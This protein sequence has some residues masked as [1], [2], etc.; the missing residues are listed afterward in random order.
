MIAKIVNKLV[1]KIETLV[2][3]MRNKNIEY[4]P[5]EELKIKR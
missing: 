4:I 2:Y 5:I 3:N 1:D